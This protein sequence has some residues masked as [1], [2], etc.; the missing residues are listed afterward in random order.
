MQTVP[1][2]YW[3]RTAPAMPLAATLPRTIDVAVIGGGLLGAATCYWLAKEGVRVALLERDAL[4][5]GATGRNGGFVV[6]GPTGSYSKAIADLGYDTAQAV[7]NV[8]H[9]SR[10]LLRQVLQEEAIAC[11][12]REPGTLRLALTEAHREQL[13]QE[14]EARQADG[15]PAQF[16]EREHI[17]MFMK[18]PMAPEILGGRLLPEQG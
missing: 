4:A 2:S 1:D 15:F 8:T 11:D 16:L 5:A 18:T 14:V 6:A 3:Q 9:E 13:T 12:Y 17:Q 7:M 10:T